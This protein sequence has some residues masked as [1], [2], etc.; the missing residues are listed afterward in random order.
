[1]K[2]VTYTDILKRIPKPDWADIVF[3]I[4]RVDL[5]TA[6]VTI[7]HI[8]DDVLLLRYDAKVLDKNSVIQFFRSFKKSAIIKYNNEVIGYYITHS[9]R[10]TRK[11][12]DLII[13]H[14]ALKV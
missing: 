12:P 7:G 3:P 4:F 8:N 13:T 10:N 11:E 9:D 6:L 2:I 1:M 5:K 14:Y